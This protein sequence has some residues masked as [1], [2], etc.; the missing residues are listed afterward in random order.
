M[1]EADDYSNKL[2]LSFSKPHDRKVS[3]AEAERVVK[4]IETSKMDV[5]L[6]ERDE[7]YNFNKYLLEDRTANNVLDKNETMLGLMYYNR[8][9]TPKSESYLKISY[10]KI[11]EGKK[12]IK[13]KNFKKANAAFDE[14]GRM[15]SKSHAVS[16]RKDG[17]SFALVLLTNARG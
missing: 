4:E 8:L 6:D 11:A 14:A 3:I 15:T 2:K 12:F 1:I 13:Q 10:A 9:L 17:L 7:T 16:D 5:L